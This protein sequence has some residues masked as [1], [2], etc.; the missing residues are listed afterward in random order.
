M[1]KLGNQV[2]DETYRNTHTYVHILQL[3]IATDSVLL[4]IMLLCKAHETLPHHLH[5]SSGSNY[6]CISTNLLTYFTEMSVET[7]QSSNSIVKL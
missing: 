2:M 1:H 5:N 7:T 4:K 3:H 6:C